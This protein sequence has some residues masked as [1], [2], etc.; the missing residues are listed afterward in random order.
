MPVFFQNNTEQP[1]PGQVVISRL[2]AAVAFPVFRRLARISPVPV[3]YHVVS[4]DGLP[5]IAN[6][7]SFR[8]T[9][10]FESDLDLLLK[11]FRALSLQEFLQFLREG[12]EPPHNAFLLS[13]DDG[14]KECHSVVAPIL[15]RKG[16]P[17][18]FFLCS[19]F[20]DNKALAYDFK[21]SLL[22]EAIRKNSPSPGV[23][24]CVRQSLDRGGICEPEPQAGI[25]AVDYER[26]GILDDIA[27]VLGL[28]F[29]A[30][31]RDREPYLTTQQAHAL[32]EKGHAI[33]AHSIDHPR[34]EDL[35]LADQ[36][37]QTLESIRFVRR[38]FSL[39]YTA[40]AFPYSDAN[41][42]AAFFRDLCQATDVDVFFGNHGLLE[43]S[44]PR[45]VQRTSMEKTWMPAEAIL[46]MAFTRRC[47][48]QIT[49]QNVVQ[50]P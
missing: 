39:N 38:Q 22:C 36:L 7:Y 10:Q 18:T 23:A 32:L 45:I 20:L 46:G 43:D 44:T 37:H 34:Y 26:Q 8:N 14:L 29:Q 15:S 6:L 35:S 21:K 17:A 31:L 19:A 48:K 12:K 9:S 5:H 50:R 13:F 40:F 49:R 41:V 25:M 11:H 47:W 30:Y 3:Y 16:V 42:S 27:A 4:D 33:G 2:L 1:L 24:Q 28:D